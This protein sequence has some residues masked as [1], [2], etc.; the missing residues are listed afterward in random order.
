MNFNHKKGDKRVKS[1]EYLR[2]VYENNA[3]ILSTFSVLNEA[4]SQQTERK[5]SERKRRSPN[6]KS[7]SLKKSQ[8][9][10]DL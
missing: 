4:F 5:T 1:D 8:L 6:R 7:P 2:K 9:L 10:S 3:K